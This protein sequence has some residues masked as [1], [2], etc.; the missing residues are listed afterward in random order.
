M[1]AGQETRAKNLMEQSKV[2]AEKLAKSFGVDVDELLK[3][4]EQDENE[5]RDNG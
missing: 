2:D 5:E 4:L 3:L 1:D